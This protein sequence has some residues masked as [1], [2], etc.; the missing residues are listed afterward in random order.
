MF[1]LLVTVEFE[2]GFIAELSIFFL[3]R[4]EGRTRI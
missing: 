1:V 4:V 3:G 2:I